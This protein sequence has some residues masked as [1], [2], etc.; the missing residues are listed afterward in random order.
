MNSI[1]KNEGTYLFID[2]S[3]LN[4]FPAFNC[5]LNEE[6]FKLENIFCVKNALLIKTHNSGIS[7]NICSCL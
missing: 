4:R 7:N 3:D 1:Q 5:R 6:Q 2:R